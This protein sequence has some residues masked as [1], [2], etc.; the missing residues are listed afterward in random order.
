MPAITRAAPGKAILVGE[1]AVVYGRPA[2]AVPV[3]QVAAR[4]SVF[5]EI[6]ATP[7][8]I[9]IEAPDIHL[10]ARLSQLPPTHSFARLISAIAAE[11]GIE[12]FPALRL[13]IHSTI[14]MAA[15]LG[16]GA[17][18]SVAVIRA[19]SAF[20][21]KPLKDERVSAL[22]FEQEKMYHGTPSGI[23]NTVIAYAQP[24]FF[25]RDQPFEILQ[26]GAAFTLVIADTGVR[27]PTAAIVGDVRTRRQS[28]MV[29]YD[30]C[31]DQ[32][33]AIAHAARRCIEAGDVGTLGPLLDQ[34]HALLQ[35]IGVSSP[36]LDALVQAA[37]GAGAWGAK[38]AGA[39]GGGNMIALVDPAQAEHIAAH[40]RSA[41]AV[42]TWVTQIAVT[43]R[44]AS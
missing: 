23:D 9:W 21:G 27:S 30:R 11:L 41:G 40:L 1:H 8:E 29:E 16:S 20:V 19:L 26:V 10:S 43:P 14:P 32:I 5:A 15:G 31:F 24:I 2:I 36:S 4:A 7:G 3:T 39:G 34:N 13:S 37:R 38:L 6:R 18:V 12:R 35:T 44:Q 33:G 25:I 28:N 17:A 22:A 42:R